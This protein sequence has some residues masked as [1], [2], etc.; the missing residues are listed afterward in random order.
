MLQTEGCSPAPLGELGAPPGHQP[1]SPS[2]LTEMEAGGEGDPSCAANDGRDPEDSQE[3]LCADAADRPLSEA[4]LPGEPAETCDCDSRSCIQAS[5]TS[6]FEA[7]PEESNT[8]EAAAET[9]ATVNKRKAV[10]KAH[11]GG[12]KKKRQSPI[13]DRKVPPPPAFNSDGATGSTCPA[14]D[15]DVGQSEIERLRAELDTLR[16]Q[17]N[18]ARKKSGLLSQQVRESKQAVSDVLK[19]LAL[20]ELSEESD[21][22]TQEKFR[23]GN[24]RQTQ[25][26][27]GLNQNKWEG[28]YE[29]EEIQG[30]REFISKDRESISKERNRLSNKT[31][32]DDKLER[33][34]IL[35]HRVAYLTR[36]EQN[37]KEREQRLQVDRSLHLKRVIRLEAARRSNF[38]GFPK[39]RDRYQLLNMIGRGG[40]SEV[41]R[42]FDLETNIYCAVKIHELGKEMSEVQ[43]QNYIRRA[44]REYEIQKGLKHPRVVTLQDCFPISHSAF[45]T[46]LEFCS[47]DTLDEYMKKHGPMLPERE[48]RG[49]VIQVLSGLRYLNT[50]ETGNKIIHYDLK[51]GNLFFQSGEVKIADFGLSKI[52]HQN[53]SGGYDSIDL[54]SRGAGTYW[55]LPPECMVEVRDG[56]ATKISNKVDVWSTGVI[57]FEM[58]FGKRPYGHGQSQEAL[59]RSTV[60]QGGFSTL[61]LPA[62]PKVQKECERYLK[63]LL[64]ISKDDRPDVHEALS[65]PYIRGIRKPRTLANQTDDEQGVQASTSHD[66]TGDLK[67]VSHDCEG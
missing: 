21:R 58:L 33:R 49:I 26:G 22:V 3:P 65:D 25:L 40:F 53:T 55:Y 11:P 2:R 4:S 30:L 15:S 34:E 29:E 62:T 32:E 46:V 14:S 66:S 67:A 50:N 7:T 13:S 41:F 1:T 61:E 35:N 39:M 56:E 5:E 64:S 10:A 38:K 27:V 43:R 9:H 31:D 48:A 42:A 23:F 45:G 54:T 8:V 18:Q 47:G 19:K 16:D 17:N 60:A 6:N 44:M 57:F 63:R 24:C 28:G 37:L 36:E 20:R 12:V 52:V 59:R 51:P